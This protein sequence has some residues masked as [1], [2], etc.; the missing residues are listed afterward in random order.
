MITADRF[1]ACTKVLHNPHLLTPVID[2]LFHE[3]HTGPSRVALG[4]T[5]L[6][7]KDWR[8]IS[9]QTCFW[10]PL[11]RQ[12]R[13]VIGENDESLVHGRGHEGHF[14]FLCNYGK[15]LVERQLVVGEVDLLDGLE[16]QMEV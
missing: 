15:C 12:L 2:W 13:P 6:V 11:L 16:L 1:A 8:H 5:A 4:Q 7:C 9:R 14:A 3:R 10:R